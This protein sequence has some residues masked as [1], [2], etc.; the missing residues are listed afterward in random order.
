MTLNLTLSGETL[1]EIIDQMRFL[2]DTVRTDEGRALLAA[3]HG[4]LPAAR[5]R[6]P[7]AHTVSAEAAAASTDGQ[8]PACAPDDLRSA[9]AAYVGRFG[10]D[11]AR[12]FLPSLLGAARVSDVP[13]QSLWR[14]KS[15][16]EA[17]ISSGKP[18]GRNPRRS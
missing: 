2:L 5:R 9:M 7:A 13:P 14:A 18:A 4:D 17:A 6:A 3:M 15:A 11:V 16:I 1:G 8:A 12:K 10:D